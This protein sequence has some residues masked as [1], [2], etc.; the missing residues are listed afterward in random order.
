[1]C[2]GILAARLQRLVDARSDSALVGREKRVARTLSQAVFFAY[3]G[4]FYNLH[5]ELEEA[6]HCLYYGN[7]LPVFLAE[8]GAVWTYNIEQARHYLAHAVEMART[9]RTLHHRCDGREI[10][11]TLILY[12]IHLLY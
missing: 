11:L 9:M 4:A 12:G 7:L 6:H 2:L 5:I 1:M 10:E 3:R 8:I